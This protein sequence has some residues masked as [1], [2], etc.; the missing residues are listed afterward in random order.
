MNADRLSDEAIRLRLLRL[1][2]LH[3]GRV[4]LT[5]LTPKIDAATRRRLEDRTLIERDC[6]MTNARGRRVRC[7]SLT[8]A[9]WRW[10]ADNFAGDVSRSS[11]CGRELAVILRM[12]QRLLED[13]NL[14]FGEAVAGLLTPGQPAH[15][16][17][18]VSPPEALERI[19]FAHQALSR[20]TGLA[21]VRI[22]DLRQRLPELAREIF[23]EA[24]RSL[25]E[26]GEA[27]LYRLDN[28]LEIH[29]ADRSAAIVTPTG[30]P[31]HLVY[32]KGTR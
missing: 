31:R 20:E 4:P 24:L 1:A 12:M 5:D 13:R 21:R 6:F 9:G 10:L 26:M 27:A 17:T 14:T 18:N 32:L 3:G 11:Q 29:D 19:R 8:D 2:L 22:A 15:A 28:P 7:L 25:E 23:D 30:Q 16:A